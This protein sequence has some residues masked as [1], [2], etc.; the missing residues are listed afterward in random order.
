MN[1]IVRPDGNIVHVCTPR[2][3]QKKLW[4]NQG[5][6]SLQLVFPRERPLCEGES[7]ICVQT[8]RNVKTLQ[9]KFDREK[10]NLSSKPLFYSSRT[11]PPVK[12]NQM[13]SLSLARPTVHERKELSKNSI[14][15]FFS[16]FLVCAL[17]LFNDVAAPVS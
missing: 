14:K 15:V 16:R 10:K 11:P 7:I 6:R 13:A 17:G 1:F 5:K 3:V 12:E 2:N 9:S 8:S 4:K